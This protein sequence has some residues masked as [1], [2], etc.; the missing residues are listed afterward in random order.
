MT[1]TQRTSLDNNTLPA[2]GML[3][4]ILFRNRSF[5]KHFRLAKL[6]QRYQVSYYTRFFSRLYADDESEAIGFNV[7]TVEVT[8]Y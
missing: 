8:W 1:V 4:L 6:F 7:E 5:V 2:A 3:G